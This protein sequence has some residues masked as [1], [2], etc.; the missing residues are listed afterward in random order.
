LTWLDLLAP[1]HYSA[2]VATPQVHTCSGG[3]LHV[4]PLGESSVPLPSAPPE[5]VALTIT[6]VGDDVLL[7]APVVYYEDGDAL[8]VLAI[9]SRHTDNA[10]AGPHLEVRTIGALRAPA[11]SLEMRVETLADGV[12]LVLARGRRCPVQGRAC[13]VEIQAL[14]WVGA[15]FIDAPLRTDAGPETARI[16][17]HETATAGS[18][19]GSS[20]RNAE[21]RRQIRADDAGVTI[22]ETIHVRR[23]ASALAENCHDEATLHRERPLTFD[24]ESLYAPASVWPLD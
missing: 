21:V 17:V 10:P 19:R 4:D 24:D 13:V 8:G 1:D 5:E 14:P 15:R 20:T 23:C 16:R 9:L 18:A 7:W 12:K 22:T 6:A 11:I 3:A 2:R